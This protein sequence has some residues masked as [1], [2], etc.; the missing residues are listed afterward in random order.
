MLD[1][2]I[3]S[4]KRICVGKDLA[5]NELFLFVARLLQRFTISAE[6]PN[7][8]TLEPAIDSVVRYP[9]SYK[10]KLTERF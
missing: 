10:A 3:V 9:M 1:Y 2:G 8:L 7:A 5:R 4:G 6:D